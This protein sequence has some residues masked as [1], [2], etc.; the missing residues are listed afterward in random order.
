M[1]I[2]RIL[3]KII[4]ETSQSFPVLLLTG[5]RQVGKTTLLEHTEKT[6]RSYITLDDIN[7][8]HAAQ[9]DPETFLNRLSLPVL[10]DEVQYA[11]KLFPYIKILVDKLKQPGLIWLTGSQQFDMMKNVSESL[12]GRVALLKLQGL[13]LAEE[14]HRLTASPFLPDPDTLATRAKTAKPLTLSQAYHCI[15]RGSYPHVVLDN[16]KTWERFYESYVTTYIQRDVHDY[17]KLKDQAPFYRF[18]QII[19]SRTGQMLNYADLSKDVGVSIPSIKSWVDALQASGLIYLLQPYFSN[20]NKRLIKT[21]KLYFMDTG[22]CCYLSGWLNP[23][24]LERGAMNGSILETYVVTEIIKSYFN[25]GK[26][27]RLFYYRDKEKRE[28]DLLIERN[29][30]LYPIEIKKTAATRNIDLKTFER[31]NSLK[32]PIAHGAVLCLTQSLLPLS[33]SIDAVPIGYI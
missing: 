1:Y 3:E 26:S 7:L 27:P 28:I 17:L 14:Q 29:G 12:A 13:S 6:S 32:M 30:S 8:R 15:W 19:A 21:P 24:V 18:M 9:A 2:K 10:I 33:E 11:P 16:G 25:A 4:Q 31:L 23:D 20:H 22:L 5:P